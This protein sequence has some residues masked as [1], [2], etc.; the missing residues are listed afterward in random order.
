MTTEI[1]LLFCR[2]THTLWKQ[3]PKISQQR[4]LGIS[5]LIL[6]HF[7]KRTPIHLSS[8]QTMMLLI[9]FNPRLFLLQWREYMRWF[10]DESVFAKVNASTSTGFWRKCSHQFGKCLY[11]VLSEQRKQLDSVR[12]KRYVQMSKN[13]CQV[14][15]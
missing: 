10:R 6:S 7:G 3:P 15:F 2:T 9:Y 13:N 8:V 1:L 5:A 4:T 14:F 11:P 12:Y